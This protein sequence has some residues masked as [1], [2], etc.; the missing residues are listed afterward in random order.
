M[1]KPKVFAAHR[2]F[3]PARKILE[4]HCDVE[5]WEKPERP[6]REEVLRRVENKEGL[7]CLLTEKVNDAETEDCGKRGGRLRQY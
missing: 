7:I 4:E 6:T 5:Y 1:A 2:L 3:D